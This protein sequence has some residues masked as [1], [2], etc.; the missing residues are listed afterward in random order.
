MER[1]IG[2]GKWGEKDGEKA[3]ET[4]EEEGGGGNSWRRA[5]NTYLCVLADP[6]KKMPAIRARA[7]RNP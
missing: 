3:E 6:R 7:P 1:R 2:C 4:G 5:S